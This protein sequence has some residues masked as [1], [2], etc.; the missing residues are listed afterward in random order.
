MTMRGRSAG[1]RWSIRWIVRGWGGAVRGAPW[2]F[3][4]AGG[5]VA[6][7]FKSRLT[8]GWFMGTFRAPAIPPAFQ[9]QSYGVIIMNA[10][11]KLSERLRANNIDRFFYLTALANLKSILAHG[12]LCR[13]AAGKLP[14][15]D[16]SDRDV[17]R[18]RGDLHR[19]V[20]LFF[21]DNTPMLYVCTEERDDVV[22]LEVSTDAVN[23]NGVWFT[24]GN[25]AA[26][27]SGRTTEYDNPEDLEK[28]DW[29]IIFSCN[30][31]TGTDRHGRDWK[32]IR[33]AEMLIPGK[34]PATHI[35][36]VYFQRRLPKN[37][38]E[39]LREIRDNSPH[40]REIFLKPSLT[41]Q[42]I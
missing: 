19:Y 32:R 30:P 33:A 42:G 5:V 23:R 31:A 18:H 3:A 12:I 37:M 8:C 34:C 35:Q 14:H 21:A 36:G 2:Q 11:R 1:G 28:L 6:W 7:C 13:N 39:K 15:V 17:Q 40:S 4:H 24:D 27:K 25:A 29:E 22:L 16:I 38:R 20:P 26:I 41:P 10:A 9:S